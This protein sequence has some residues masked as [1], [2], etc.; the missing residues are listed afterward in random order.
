MKLN[1]LISG[2]TIAT[3][4]AV[5]AVPSHAK[6]TYDGNPDAIAVCRAIVDDNSTDLKQAIRRAAPRHQKTHSMN[7]LADSFECNGQSLHDFA[8]EVG[9]YDALDV[10]STDVDDRVAVR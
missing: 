4:A 8:V 10:I 3:A 7:A 6:V 9:A 2:L 1:T 5:V